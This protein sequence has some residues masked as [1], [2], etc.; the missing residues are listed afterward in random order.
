MRHVVLFAV[1]IA[2]LA[3]VAE[4]RTPPT[5]STVGV[6][7]EILDEWAVT[8]KDPKADLAAIHPKKALICHQRLLTAPGFTGASPA[9]A[10][11]YDLQSPSNKA[12][13]T[14]ELVSGPV[15]VPEEIGSAWIDA[16]RVRGAY[17]D[18]LKTL[19]VLREKQCSARIVQ[20]FGVNGE[21]GY[22]KQNG[23]CFIPISSVLDALNQLIP[24][25]KPPVWGYCN[26][27]ENMGDVV[28]FHAAMKKEHAEEVSPQTNIA[29]D[30][31]AYASP[32][33]ARLTGAGSRFAIDHQEVLQLVNSLNEPDEDV[34]GFLAMYL[35]G[36]NL[37][38]QYLALK[39]PSWPDW[40][41]K[42]AFD[43]FPK[44]SLQTVYAALSAKKSKIDVHLQSAA[45]KSF[46]YSRFKSK[47]DTE[48]CSK[49]AAYNPMS[50]VTG[51]PMSYATITNPI[52]TGTLAGRPA[53]VV[54]V[55]DP[56]SPLNVYFSA[57][58]EI[59]ASAVMY[60]LHAAEI[61]AP[62][63]K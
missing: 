48:V 28:G 32:A 17:R 43:V 18:V 26:P 19:E 35:H 46:C 40:A 21:I 29:I 49:I 45:V 52:P 53:L 11:T 55:R 1:C 8:A 44:A 51:D 6:E 12:L 30:V 54:E 4:A 42:G 25:A 9:L 50:L 27:S 57:H 23:D 59:T 3:G 34:R 16:A 60:V 2:G 38:H 22:E 33:L 62:R 41:L 39:N 37:Y 61:L 5:Q 36:V 63:A 7:W 13:Y 58:Q 56:Q 14:L 24:E 20:V 31:A 47:L 10:I 15:S